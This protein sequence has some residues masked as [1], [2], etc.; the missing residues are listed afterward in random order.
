[1]PNAV[2]FVGRTFI[3]GTATNLTTGDTSEFSACV[4]AQTPTAVT[5]TSINGNGRSMIPAVLISTA[6]T[7]ILTWSLLKKRYQPSSS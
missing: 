1:V 6:I 4:Q 5:L 7:G 3:S 2:S